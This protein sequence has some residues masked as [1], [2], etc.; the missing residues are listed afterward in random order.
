MNGRGR[1]ERLEPAVERAEGRGFEGAP[2]GFRFLDAGPRVREQVA[3]GAGGWRVGAFEVGLEGGQ[4]SAHGLGGF[5]G[6]AT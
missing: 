6:A 5:V 1:A 4:S 3:L 2:A